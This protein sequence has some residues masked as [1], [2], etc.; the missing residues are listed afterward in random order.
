MVVLISGRSRRC[1]I[2]AVQASRRFTTKE[3]PKMEP[4]NEAPKPLEELM[5]ICRR[6]SS[7][8]FIAAWRGDGNGSLRNDARFCP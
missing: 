1:R 8:R 4:L 2:A 5:P 6:M 7:Q 3:P